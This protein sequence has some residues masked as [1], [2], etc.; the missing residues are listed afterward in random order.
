MLQRNLWHEA[1]I[2][3][4]PIWWQE[5]DVGDFADSSQYDGIDS[6]CAVALDANGDGH[7][8]IYVVNYQYQSQLFLN[9]GGFPPEFNAVP[10]GQTGHLA[11]QQ[12]DFGFV[13]TS[14]DFDGDG[15]DE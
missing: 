6:V 8:D 4:G 14:A 9:D 2:W 10:S 3:G 12:T 11:S 5:T 13:V 1:G 7:M 15:S